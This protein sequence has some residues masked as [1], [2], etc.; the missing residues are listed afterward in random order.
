VDAITAVERLVAYKGV[1]QKT[2]EAAIEAF[3]ASK[4]FDVL[5][6]NPDKVVEKLG[7]RRAQPIIEGFNGDAP[8]PATKSAAAKKAT[9]GSRGGKGRRKKTGAP[10]A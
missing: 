6:T 1:G 2:A 4:L 9:R 5:R 7:A 3:G 10:R 8:K